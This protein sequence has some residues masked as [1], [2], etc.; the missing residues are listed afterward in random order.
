MTFME[1]IKKIVKEKAVMQYKKQ[2]IDVFTADVVLSTYNT[3]NKINKERLEKIGN[4]NPL[5]AI[6]MCYNLII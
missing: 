2:P 1:I 5:S 3:I 4:E 6:K